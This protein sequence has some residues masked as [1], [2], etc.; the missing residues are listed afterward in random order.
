MDLA[1]SSAVQRLIAASGALALLLVAV[2]VP[3]YLMV[4]L[5]AAV[6][7]FA[8]LLFYQFPLAMVGAMVLTY[9]FGI[10]I[11]LDVPTETGGGGG[12][13]AALGS[14]VF[15]VVPFALAGLL[16]LR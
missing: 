14:S 2:L 7:A 1:F 12:S 11:K 10:D 5:P 9:G 6:A 13:V 4:L 3:E 16:V 8:A 15:R